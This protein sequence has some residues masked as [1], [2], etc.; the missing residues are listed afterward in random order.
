MTTSTA[1]K[2]TWK[3]KAWRSLDELVASGALRH[4]SVLMTGA[5]GFLGGHFLYW[6]H[7]AGG[8]VAALV[9]A[10]DEG[11]A[12]RRLMLRQR[13][14]A[15]AYAHV[16]ASGLGAITAVPGDV[17]LSLFA[18]NAAQLR[19]LASEN[20]ETVWHFAASLRFEKAHSSELMADNVGGTR[21]AMAT[22]AAIGARRFV[23]IS[24]AYSCGAAEGLV[25]EELH[26]F[27]RPFNNA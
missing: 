10:P 9:R 4:R 2:M 14:S 17:R 15:A 6:W 25:G 27:A 3:K 5:T 23:Y 19:A 16:A 7:R 26:S 13:A 20:I 1:Q 18:L 12:R 8:R 11:S 22:A 21:N 24:T